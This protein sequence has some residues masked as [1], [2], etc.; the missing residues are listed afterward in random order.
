MRSL[1]GELRSETAFAYPLASAAAGEW[2]LRWFTAHAESN[3]CGHAT[4]ATVHVLYGQ[5]PTCPQYRFNTP[6][7]KLAAHAREDGAIT[8]DLPAAPPVAIPV[9][10]GLVEALQEEPLHTFGTGTL[11]DLMVLVRD[12]DAVRGLRPRSDETA[13]L[14]RR[15]S[16]RG[17]IVTAQAR[18]RE[19]GYDFV[20]RYFAPG[21][22]LEEDQVTGSAHA[23]LGP[24]WTHRVDR[25][26][27]T[28]LQ[29]SP[30]SGAVQTEVRANRVHL[31]G[32]AVTTM[33][34]A[35][36]TSAVENR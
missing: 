4:L 18:S 25:K 29:V 5:Q 32:H 21:N 1:A 15:D 12:E 14:C 26:T 2:A 7:G 20:S 24:F 27:L 28:G 35:I 30:R 31:T 11:G 9:P 3:I 16:L 34:G 36:A 22:G 8:L 33:K 23:V 13:A 17:I 19:R 10:A 6:A